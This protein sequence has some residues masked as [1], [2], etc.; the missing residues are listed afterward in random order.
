MLEDLRPVRSGEI[1]RMGKGVLK[2]GL[3]HALVKEEANLLNG[4]VKQ[5]PLSFWGDLQSCILDEQHSLY[6]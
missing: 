4:N 2:S 3:A 5:L 6:I 1:N